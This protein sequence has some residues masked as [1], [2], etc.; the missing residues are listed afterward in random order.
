[1]HF[2]QRRLNLAGVIT[3]L[4]QRFGQKQYRGVLWGG[5][6]SSF[7]ALQELLPVF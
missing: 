1:V 2:D 3:S 4:V 6:C 7:P 5:H